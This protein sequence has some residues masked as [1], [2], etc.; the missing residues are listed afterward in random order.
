MPNKVNFVGATL[1][2]TIFFFR[3]LPFSPISRYTF[4]FSFFGLLTNRS[5]STTMIG[6]LRDVCVGLSLA[7]AKNVYVTKA[8]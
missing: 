3:F 6:V 8:L 1:E 4:P 5:F 2:G 7:D